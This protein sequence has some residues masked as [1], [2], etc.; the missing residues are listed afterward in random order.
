MCDWV[1]YLIFSLDSNETYIGSSNNQP[2]RL[3]NHNNNNS[4][5]KRTGAKRTRGKLWVPLIIISG[6]IDS[7]SCLSFEAGWKRLAKK[8][9]NGR[10]S[11]INV[12]SKSQ[13]SYTKN[14]KWN[15]IMDLLYFCHNFTHYESKFKLN[16]DMRHPLA[17]PPIMTVNVFFEKWMIDLPWPYFIQFNTD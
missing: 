2:K 1:C 7:K 14:T 4:D 11:F 16:H 12:M 17:Q 15:R 10:L 3:N 9:N 5:I 8:R 6:F 13:L